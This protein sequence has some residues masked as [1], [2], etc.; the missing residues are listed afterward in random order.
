MLSRALL[1]NALFD[2]PDQRVDRLRRYGAG[3]GVDRDARHLVLHR[4][5][6]LHDRQE[7]LQIEQ[8]VEGRRNVA[9]LQPIDGRRREVDAAD[10]DVARLLARLL[11][12]FGEL[13]GDVAVLGSDRLQLRV[14]LDVGGEDRNGERRI[15]VHLLT[16]VETVDLE[17]GLLKRVS[18]PFTRLAA[19]SLA[20]R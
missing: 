8:L 7:A 5:D 17:A 20:E 16:D 11:E 18:E 13:A 19:L 15:A 6:A 12:D 4:Q 1:P 14:R 9:R 10:D 2:E 3:P